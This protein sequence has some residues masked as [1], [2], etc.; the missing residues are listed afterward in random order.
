[1]DPVFDDVV[2]LDAP[3]PSRRGGWG[4]RQTLLAGAVALLVAIVMVAALLVRAGTRVSPT[5]LV[6]SAAPKA[7]WTFDADAGLSFDPIP[8][9]CGEG[10]VAMS[11]RD[12]GDKIIRCIEVK[13]GTLAWSLT[14]PGL[15][16]ATMSDLPGTRFLA[17]I[18]G[19]TAALVNKTN[20][21]RA[22]ELALPTTG[23]DGTESRVV[24]APDGAI[25]VTSVDLS[26]WVEPGLRVEKRNADDPTKIEWTAN[27]G[28]LDYGIEVARRALLESGHSLLWKSYY[29]DGLYSAAFDPKDGSIPDWSLGS[30]ALAVSGDVV[31]RSDES[32]VIAY[33]IASG[34]RLWS[35]EGENRVA[36]G[37][38]AGFVVEA[39][40]PEGDGGSNQVS[41]VDPATGRER[42]SMRLQY[43]AVSPLDTDRGTLLW[44]WGSVGAGFSMSMIDSHGDTAWTWQSEEIHGE[45]L[46]LGDGVIVMSCLLPEGRFDTVGVD[47][48]TGRERWRLKDVQPIVVDGRVYGTD[49][50]SLTLYR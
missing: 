22:A 11:L 32:G 34:R 30:Q 24:S 21:T 20:G 3:A 16:G 19:K 23:V 28:S 1:M 35:I 25:F 43:A 26:K 29:F 42:W 12:G 13:D 17:A 6:G 10:R 33:D 37:A 2:D 38:G 31:A 44:N 9:G 15:E 18:D 45:V 27:L 4:R 46:G 36:F 40:I 41:L 49:G 50:A 39:F 8:F 7:A 48:G 47:I 14:L 5:L